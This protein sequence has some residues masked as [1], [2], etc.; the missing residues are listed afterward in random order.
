MEFSGMEIFFNNTFIVV[1]LLGKNF[2][3][4]LMYWKI[5]GVKY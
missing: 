4:Q 5:G 1:K 2:Y 3:L